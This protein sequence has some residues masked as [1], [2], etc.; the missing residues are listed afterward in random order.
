MGLGPIDVFV[1]GAT[2]YDVLFGAIVLRSCC[3]LFSSVV[4]WE[5][6]L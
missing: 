1:S 4:H 2:S 5:T 6:L 3:I